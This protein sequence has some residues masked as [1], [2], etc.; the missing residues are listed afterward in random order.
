MSTLV[1]ILSFHFYSRFML[2]SSFQEGVFAVRR[3]CSEAW[4]WLLL[5]VCWI[6]YVGKMFA[7][8]N[9]PESL[10]SWYMGEVSTCYFSD[11]DLF[12][13]EFSSS[14]IS[15]L[16]HSPWRWVTWESQTLNASLHLQNS[17]TAK[18]FTIKPFAFKGPR[19]SNIFRTLL[20]NI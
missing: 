13:Q 15:V 18:I 6:L 11:L 17:P 3:V 20:G 7:Y 19:W 8:S 5:L 4:N 9:D 12:C 14:L 2:A 16:Y 10:S 1:S